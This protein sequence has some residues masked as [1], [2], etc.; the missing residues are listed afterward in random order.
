MPGRPP[1]MEDGS[2]GAPAWS[3]GGGEHDELILHSGLVRL[4]RR[5]VHDEAPI[6][7]F[8][9]FDIDTAELGAP[10]RADEPDKQG[11]WEDRN[12]MWR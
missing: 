10:E 8:E 2:D 3:G 4:R 7:G 12:Q 9:V 11:S 1:P 5:N 6:V